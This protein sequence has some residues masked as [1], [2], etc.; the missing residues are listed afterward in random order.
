LG[1]YGGAIASRL[2]QH[3]WPLLAVDFDPNS[4]DRGRKLGMKV[5]YGDVGDPEI[6]AQ[7]P[8][9]QAP[10]VICTVRDLNINTA[11]FNFLKDAGFSGRIALTA[12]EPAHAEKYQKMGADAVLQPFIDAAEQAAETITG[13]I[14]ALPGLRDW[15]ARLEEVFLRPGTVFAGKTLR[16]LNLRGEL[17]VTVLA[18]SRAGKVYFNPHPEFQMYPG[19]QLILLGAPERS[20][21]AVK[22]LRQREFG[23]PQEQGKAFDAVEIIVPADSPWV[24]KTLAALDF[25]KQYGVTIIGIRRGKEQITSPSASDILQPQDSIIVVGEP[26]G[27]AKMKDSQQAGQSELQKQT[28]RL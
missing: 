11:L 13:R 22:H 3:G 8:L 10:W 18:V 12:A 26:E 9:A 21:E 28:P 19:D 5:L 25:P 17:G 27:V 2:L 6:H 24:G 23:R 14:E 7:L 4:L 1:N 15:P 16:E 20:A